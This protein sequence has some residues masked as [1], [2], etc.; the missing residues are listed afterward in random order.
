MGGEKE[1]NVKNTF[2]FR[3]L[4]SHNKERTPLALSDCDCDD[5]D[6]AD[7]DTWPSTI[8]WTFSTQ[9]KGHNHTM[10]KMTGKGNE[11]QVE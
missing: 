10:N 3:Q 4:Y 9:S 2:T 5:D 1:E 11:T 7:D 6:G 8:E